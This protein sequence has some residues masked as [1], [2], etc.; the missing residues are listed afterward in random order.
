MDIS[1]DSL[2][3]F[4]AALPDPVFI[5]AK[6]GR[7]AGLFGGADSRYYH[8]G[9]HLI[10]LSLHDVLPAD[11][12]EDFL[13]QIAVCL[14]EQRLVIFEYGLSGPDVAGLDETRG[15]TGEIRFQGHLS[16]FRALVEGEQAVIWVARNITERHLLEEQLRH[17]SETDPLTGLYNRRRFLTEVTERLNEFQRYGQP[18]SLIMLDIDHFKQINDSFGHQEGDRVICRVCELWR[19]QL[20]EVDVFARFGGEEFTVLLP[21]T[22]LASAAA[23]TE[24]LRTAVEQQGKDDPNRP[25]PTISLGVGCFVEGDTVDSL[26]ARVDA[27][28]YRAKSAG[29]NRVELQE[30]PLPA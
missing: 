26:I 7:Y 27:A 18:A 21:H 15:P 17:N 6:S 14:E 3:A 11:K 22:P 20:R 19:Q 1:Y 25:A 10:G 12:A 29:R 30:E 13:R 9:S 2:R 24:R 16:P 28:L 5:I 8:D 23:S 4:L